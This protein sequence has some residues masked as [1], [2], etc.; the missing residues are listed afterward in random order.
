VRSRT[1]RLPHRKGLHPSERVFTG[2]DEMKE[3][4]TR[5]KRR[6]GERYSTGLPQY[7]GSYARL[8]RRLATAKLCLSLSVF[9]FQFPHVFS[10]HLKRV[11]RYQPPEA[12]SR[13]TMA[14]IC[15]M[16]VCEQIITLL[17][18][19]LCGWNCGFSCER[20]L[21]CLLLCI[22]RP[23]EMLALWYYYL[24]FPHVRTVWYRIFA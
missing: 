9:V 22:I 15:F 10:A 20:R 17:V 12:L 16:D 5:R 4:E 3:E 19:S 21:V 8:L 1:L 23:I 13:Y 7:L 11:F 18:D 14:Y 6:G 24:C 2:G